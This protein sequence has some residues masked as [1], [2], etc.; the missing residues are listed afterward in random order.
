MGDSRRVRTRALGYLRELFEPDGER[1]G[2][3]FAHTLQFR[4]GVGRS[5]AGRVGW[6]GPVRGTVPG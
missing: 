4:D 3:A 5:F 2:E 6:I 1:L